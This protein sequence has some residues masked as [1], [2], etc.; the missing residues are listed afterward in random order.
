MLLLASVSTVSAIGPL[1]PNMVGKFGMAIGGLQGVANVA[2]PEA[3]LKSYGWDP[4]PENLAAVKATGTA[5]LSSTATFLPLVLLKTSV[6]KALT[7]GILVRLI[8]VA[9]Y[10]A[11]G[12][13][14]L[15]GTKKEG[16][17]VWFALNLAV[18]TGLWQNADWALGWGIK[19]VA[20]IAVLSGAQM[21]ISP[22]FALTKYGSKSS[23][24]TEFGLLA[25]ALGGILAGSGLATYALA[26]GK[27]A[28]AA[29]GYSFVPFSLA[30]IKSVFVTKQYQ[31]ANMDIAPLI[32]WIVISTIMIA[33]LAF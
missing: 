12:H 24:G 10:L 13:D 22:A 31:K 15:V 1:N 33:T 4:S 20:A 3:T 27:D 21:A 28:M 14:Q 25:E 29:I 16:T 26:T 9:D 19:A 18:V 6:T 17:I 7:Y 30:L 5:A 32:G 8:F 2:I 23:V 11:Q